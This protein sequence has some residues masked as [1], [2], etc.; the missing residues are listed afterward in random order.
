[1]RRII[2]LMIIITIAGLGVAGCGQS[3]TASKQTGTTTKEATSKMF[4]VKSDAFADGEQMPIKYAGTTIVGGQNMSPPLAWD[5]APAGTKS[6]ALICVDRNPVANDWV[7]WAVINIPA[8]TS[9]LAEGASGAKMPVGVEELVNTFGE[10]GWGGPTPPTGTGP[11]EYEFI[12][13]ALSS[14]KIEINGAPSLTQFE[15]AVKAD[16][17]GTAKIKGVMER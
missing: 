3:G 9:S 6:F 7:H 17:L 10:K 5:G 4:E 11:H 13:Y 14:A 16:T 8:E 15:E 12:L 1:M 2:P